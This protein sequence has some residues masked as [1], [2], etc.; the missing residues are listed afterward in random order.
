MP[1]TINFPPEEVI[2]PIFGKKDFELIILW[3]VNNNE[4][5]TWA[6]LKEL[7]KPSTLSI[8]L[9]N[10]Q[11]KDLIVKKEFNQYSITSK[12]KDRF[13][14]LSQSK[15]TKRKLNFPPDAILWKRNYDHWILW[16][17]YNNSYCKWADFLNEPLSINN[18]S[19][20]KN[21]NQLMEDGYV[22]KEDKEYR[23]TQL[24]KSEYSNMLRD[25]DLDRQSILEE[26]SKRIHDNTKKTLKFFKKFKI[27]DEEIKFRFLNNL[28]RLPYERVK[29]NLESEEDFH[30][31]L[32]YLSLNHPKH[33][34]KFISTEKFASKYNLELVTL[35][36]YVHQI[37][38]K[39]IYPTKFF[40]LN[41]E[42]AGNYYL[43]TNEKLEQVLNAVVEEHITK[44]TYLNKLYEEDK[45]TSFSTSLESAINAIL[46]EIC[47]SI[48]EE[49]ICG[50]LRN[51]LPEYI[52]YLAYK[53]EKEKKLFDAY[54]KLKGLI[55]HEI[56]AYSSEKKIVQKYEKYEESIQE[57]NEAINLNPD[58]FDLYLSKQS[59][60]IYFNKYDEI[61]SFLDEILERF[62]DEHKNVEIKRAY[63]LKEQ[64]NIEDGLEIIKNLIENYPDDTDLLIYKAYWLQY[65][66]RKEEALE[67]IKE[68]IEENPNNG[69]YHDTYGE[70]LMSF[71][72]YATAKNE[73]LVSIEL[74]SDDWYIFQ[75]YIKLGICDKELG[76]VDQALENLNRGKK[77]MENSR[78][79]EET[80]QKWLQIANLF[81]AQIE[82]LR[83]I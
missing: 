16:M 43:Q 44:F 28:L 24:G 25:Y 30:K 69:M 21:M 13:Y 27:T 5:C 41:A 29:S 59:V 39:Q 19:L 57:I 1:P 3:M 26:E 6:N 81:L 14:E 7:V 77:L 9:K 36:Y 23:I 71:Q 48:F 18:S 42:S 15:K 76:N 31:I 74:S 61:L 83:Q 72:D 12:G 75:T 11:K 47:G 32:L 55:W 70:M 22:K 82:L 10:L 79:E 46:K 45:D 80:K 20:S 64:R 50:A 2:K 8:Y 38:D 49:G 73:F 17:V 68:L 4:L 34:P 58:D 56:L 63:I 33:Y 54:D 52:N 78:S 67:T 53:V 37:V 35:E 62:P 40:K 60:L 66:A 51:F 65:L